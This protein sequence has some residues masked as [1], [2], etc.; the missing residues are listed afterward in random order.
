METTAH[1]LFRKLDNLITDETTQEILDDLMV[2][3][4]VLAD[5][6]ITMTEEKDIHFDQKEE[7]EKQL[8]DCEE[9]IDLINTLKELGQNYQL[10]DNQLYQD[11]ILRLL[12]EEFGI[13][14]IVAPAKNQ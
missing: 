5:E 2:E 14:L 3:I 12:E 8:E 13:K 7:L 4:D 10:S 9:S 11:E 6:L 1:T